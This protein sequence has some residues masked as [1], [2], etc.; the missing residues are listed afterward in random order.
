MPRDWGES[1]GV[2]SPLQEARPRQAES[3]SMKTYVVCT[4][5]HGRARV[6]LGVARQHLAEVL[7][8]DRR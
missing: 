5:T 2:F 6:S 7:K 3:Q 4:R 8:T 1:A